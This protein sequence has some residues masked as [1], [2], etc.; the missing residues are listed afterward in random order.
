MTDAHTLLAL[1]SDVWQLRLAPSLGGAIIDA[2]WRGHDVLRPTG[3]EQ[4]ALGNARKTACYPLVPFSN[5]VGYGRFEFDGDTHSL[6]ANFP[7]EPHAVHGVGFQRAWTVDEH[8][9]RA[10]D[11]HLRHAPD[12]SWPFAFDARQRIGIDGDRLVLTL[13]VTN[14]DQRR[15]P[16]GLGWHPFFP[17]QTAAG[18]TRLATQWDAMLV[19]GA[20]QLP[21][22]RVEPPALQ[23][24]DD[25]VID[26]C[27]TGWNRR[28][29]IDTPHHH[30]CIDASDTLRCV[31]LFRPE[32][33]PFFAFEPVSHPNNALN[34]IEPP[35]H[36]LEPG[37]TLEGEVVLTLSPH[38]TDSSGTHP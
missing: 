29:S 36:V 5:R 14:L 1:T 20:D 19:S 27:L 28:A 12:R 11:M 35:M 25:T 18:K 17:L 24:L 38:S 31:V 2:R 33:Q 34:G 32:G 22:E 13:S 37:A 16:C 9:E 23:A 8:S 7:G 3:D 10:I 4:L 6:H 15:A 26:N 30:I 21:R